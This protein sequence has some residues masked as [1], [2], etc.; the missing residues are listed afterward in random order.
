ML[1]VVNNM[2]VIMPLQKKK[3]LTEAV[4]SRTE[5]SASFRY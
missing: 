1:L 4:V 3:F 5:F 2:S